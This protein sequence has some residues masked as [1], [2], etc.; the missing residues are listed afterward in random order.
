MMNMLKPFRPKTLYDNY[1]RLL[2][3][4][5]FTTKSI[6]CAALYGLGDIFCQGIEYAFD[7][8]KEFKFSRT[9]SVMVYGLLIEG[10]FLHVSYTYW[11]PRWVKGHDN[12]AALKKMLICE[13]F[14]TLYQAISYYFCIPLFEGGT[15]DDSIAEL[16]EKLWETLKMN[17]TVWPLL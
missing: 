11:L 16:R 15:V 9:R 13:T 10:P 5:P 3:T 12:I 1:I 17:W 7:S 8:T 4:K 6:T 14:F 2:D